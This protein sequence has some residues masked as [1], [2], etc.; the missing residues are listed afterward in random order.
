SA[1]P[2]AVAFPNQ[3]LRMECRQNPKRSFRP[4]SARPP[5]GQVNAT[6]LRR[7]FGSARSG[8]QF[9]PTLRHKVLDI[10]ARWLHNTSSLQ[11]M[12]VLAHLERVYGELRRNKW[13][14]WFAIFCRI[15][16]AFGFVP[17]GIVKVTGERF[18][19]L[20]LEHPL[21]HYFDA[22]LLTGSYYTFI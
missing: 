16:L 8:P 4:V 22:L 6:Q 3:F 14:R 15:A 2:F 13:V 19:A 21:G 20:P 10:T 11:P 9:E 1:F 5:Q 7:S 12:S 17:A 18:T